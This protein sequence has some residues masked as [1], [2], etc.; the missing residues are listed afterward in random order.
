MTNLF[1]YG[2]LKSGERA[3]G[4]LSRW[5]PKFLG[6]FKTAPRYHLYEQG[7][8]PG[9]VS[10][11]SIAGGVY[12]E[13]YEVS[14]DC[15][16]AMDYYEGVE[17]GLFRRETIELQDGS[18]AIAYFIVNPDRDRRITGGRWKDGEA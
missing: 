11:D 10:D 12:G 18:K 4:L 5:N 6:E 8:F 7:F 1:V 13:L 2:T 3:H 15:M 16:D 14:D 9:M 17:S